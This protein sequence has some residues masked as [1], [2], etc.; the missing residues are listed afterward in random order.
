MRLRALNIS[1]AAVSRFL[2]AAISLPHEP[3]TGLA[4]IAD[5]DTLQMGKTRIRLFG[6]DAPELHACV[7]GA[8]PLLGKVLWQT[9]AARRGSGLGTP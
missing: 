7:I 2:V 6:I 3:V 8:I 1:D 5:G 4:R 9:S